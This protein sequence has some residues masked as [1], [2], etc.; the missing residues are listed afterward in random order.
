MKCQFIDIKQAFLSKIKVELGAAFIV[1]LIQN[2]KS[3][4]SKFINLL[5]IKKNRKKKIDIW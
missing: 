5:I 2:I 1:A 3:K 4:N